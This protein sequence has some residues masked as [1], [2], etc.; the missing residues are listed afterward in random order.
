MCVFVCGGGLLP[1]LNIVTFLK[2]E[3]FEHTRDSNVGSLSL[4]LWIDNQVSGKC[5][6]MKFM[7]ITEIVRFDRSFV[8]NDNISI[9]LS[10]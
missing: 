6:Q 1:R 9:P 3:M 4:D 2:L 10:I 5:V 8:S 7:R